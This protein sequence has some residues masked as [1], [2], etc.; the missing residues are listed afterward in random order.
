[1]R[2]LV[3]LLTIG[4]QNYKQLLFNKTLTFDIFN[5]PFKLLQIAFDRLEPPI[6]FGKFLFHVTVPMV[7]DV[8]ISPAIDIFADKCPRIAINKMMKI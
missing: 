7:L 1:M 8:I 4:Q 2:N 6:I 3:F 5:G